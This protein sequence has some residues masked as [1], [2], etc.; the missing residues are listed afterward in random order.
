MVLRSDMKESDYVM[1]PDDMAAPKKK[2]SGS[3]KFEKLATK[4]IDYLG[5]TRRYPLFHNGKFYKYSGTHYTE[6]RELCF[7]I[8]SFFKANEL[9]QSNNII[10]NVLPIVH[11]YAHRP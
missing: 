4:Y 10:G 7:S 5:E 6:D 2:T 3:A 8:R 1:P 9:P 11:M